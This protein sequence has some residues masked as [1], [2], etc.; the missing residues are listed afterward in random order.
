[1][2]AHWKAFL[3]GFVCIA[4]ASSQ[5]AV[6]APD[7]G[8]TRSVHAD[9]DSL[10]RAAKQFLDSRG[11]KVARSS[12]NVDEDWACGTGYRCIHFKNASPRSAE[13]K[14]LGRAEIV[15]GYLNGP[16]DF[17]WKNL[18][19]GYWAAPDRDFTMGAALELKHESNGCTARCS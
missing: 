17:R 9:C 11:L 10:A 15:S 13:G 12:T 8:A 6:D 19:R 16:V 1:M 7:N 3:L 18:T 2:N 5:L 14:P 4:S